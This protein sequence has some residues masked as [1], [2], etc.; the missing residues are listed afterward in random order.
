MEPGLRP[1]GTTPTAAPIRVAGQRVVR[2][3]AH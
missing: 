1:A 2:Y 3:E